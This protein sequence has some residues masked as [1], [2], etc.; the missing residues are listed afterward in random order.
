VEVGLSRFSFMGAPGGPFSMMLKY[1]EDSKSIHLT[2]WQGEKETT[3][4]Q[5]LESG[6]SLFDWL[7]SALRELETHNDV[8]FFSLLSP[9]I[10]PL[11]A[12]VIGI[13]L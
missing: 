6:E 3:T 10:Y 1:F 7:N 8:C 12:M 13:A 5:T 11:I 4:L 9:R 2:R